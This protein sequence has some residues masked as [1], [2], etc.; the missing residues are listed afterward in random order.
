MATLNASRVVDLIG[1][2]LYARPQTP[3]AR[4][5]VNAAGHLFG[6]AHVFTGD[7]ID[8]I[9]LQRVELRSLRQ[10]ADVLEPSGFAS[11]LSCL[12]ALFVDEK[13]GLICAETIDPKRHW[14]INET[15]HF[16]LKLASGYHASALILATNDLAGGFASSKIVRD[17]TLKLY[18]KG[19]AINVPLL[20][21]VVLTVAGWQSMFTP[22]DDQRF[23]A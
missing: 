12:S 4:Q 9:W 13:C 22:H 10:I 18:H 16:I 20:D 19:D 11:R 23:S 2:L 15:T 7:Q 14:D 5:Q 1:R 3:V 8:S 17:L 21:H 6:A